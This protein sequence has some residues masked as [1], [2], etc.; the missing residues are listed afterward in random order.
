MGLIGNMRHDHLHARSFPARTHAACFL[1]LGL[2]LAAGAGAC[3]AER[4][5]LVQ[6]HNDDIAEKMIDRLEVTTPL[7]HA[8][9][10]IS[11]MRDGGMVKFPVEIGIYVPRG[12][13]N[14]AVTVLAVDGDTVVGHGDVTIDDGRLQTNPV[15]LCPGV[16]EDC[17]VKPQDPVDAGC[18]TGDDGGV[19]ADG[20][21]VTTDGSSGNCINYCQLLMSDTGCPELYGSGQVCETVC[22][23][24]SV[25]AAVDLSCQARLLGDTGATHEDK[26]RGGGIV[27]PVCL[28]CGPFCDVWTAA[29]GTPSQTRDCYDTCSHN[30][31]NAS[32]STATLACYSGWLTRATQ[33]RTY[34]QWTLP[35]LRCGGGCL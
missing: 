6:V 21:P 9:D 8:P 33:N 23:L 5:V 22:A 16:A 2:A 15:H 7:R 17:P 11:V 24:A 30:F 29:C 27:S 18:T 10:S 28:P 35:G 20:G 13:A 4:L 32:D 34:C 19:I 25:N 14:L 1:A 3:S 31:G 12:V 26:C